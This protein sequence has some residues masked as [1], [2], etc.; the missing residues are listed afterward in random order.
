[1][2]GFQGLR[3]KDS[4]FPTD[5]TP[6]SC[7]PVPPPISPPQVS[8]SFPSPGALLTANHSCSDTL[9][10]SVSQSLPWVLWKLR[11]VI[12]RGIENKERGPS[13]SLWALAPL[14]PA[15]PSLFLD[16]ELCSPSTQ[17]L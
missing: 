13:P 14:S 7:F 6:W 15:F 12:K 11:V 16:L 3:V 9:G 8:A 2:G 5:R 10:S 4:V 1:M 17:P